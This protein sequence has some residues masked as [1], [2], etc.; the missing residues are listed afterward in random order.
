[1]VLALGRALKQEGFL[2][3]KKEN[4]NCSVGMQ[5]YVISKYIISIFLN[6]KREL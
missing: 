5:R 2:L 3:V 6:K 4:P 1:M